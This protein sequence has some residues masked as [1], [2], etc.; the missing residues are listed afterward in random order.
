MESYHVKSENSIRTK[1]PWGTFI[2][3]NIIYTRHLTNKKD[4]VIPHGEGQSYI[5]YTRYRPLFFVSFSNS[6]S[7]D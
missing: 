5:A 2:N 3:L 1:G 6:K 7:I 4:V